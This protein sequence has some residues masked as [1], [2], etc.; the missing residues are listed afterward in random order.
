[1]TIH[2]RPYTEAADLQRILGLKRTCT[3]PENMYDAPTLSELRALLAPFPQD[4]AA[5]RPPWEDGRE[6]S[7]GTSTDGRG[8]SRRLCSGWRQMGGS[9]PTLL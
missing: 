2:M 9:W 3:T 4:P 1:M 6:E 5:E 8:P 7:L